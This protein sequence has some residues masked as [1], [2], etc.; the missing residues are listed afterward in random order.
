M[1][2]PLVF[3][4]FKFSV[5]GES[6]I[7]ELTLVEIWNWL[8]TNEFEGKSKTSNCNEQIWHS[9]SSNMGELLF[10]DDSLVV[11]EQVDS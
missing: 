10:F 3:N 11:F 7:T 6:L 2:G 1:G 4:E 8:S 9:S 5:K